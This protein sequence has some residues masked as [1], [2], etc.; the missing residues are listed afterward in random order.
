MFFC[1][2]YLSTGIYTEPDKEYDKERK[3]RKGAVAIFINETDGLN[4][5]P[6]GSYGDLMIKG[7]LDSGINSYADL[8]E[9]LKRTHPDCAITERRLAEYARCRH[10][11]PKEKA[12]LIL[13]VLGKDTDNED[14]NAALRKSREYARLMTKETAEAYT[15]EIKVSM[16]LKPE[17]ILPGEDPARTAALINIRA[18]EIGKN[19]GM[20]EYVEALIRKDLNEY[21]LDT[22]K[23]GED[24]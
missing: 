24:N 6:I 20:R 15:Q 4:T 23:G 11:P 18:Q 9:L 8:E 2:F 19:G 5:V 22:E 13:S 3:R 12:E 14:L 16:R 21:I 17:R 7:M 10:V 1:T